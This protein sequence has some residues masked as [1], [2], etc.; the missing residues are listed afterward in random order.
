M[1]AQETKFLHFLAWHNANFIIPV[2]QRNYDWKREQCKQ[3]FD[4]I[5][6]ITK[7]NYRTHFMW[8]IVAYQED[9]YWKELLI[10]DWQQRLTT[11]SLL[12]LALYKVLKNNT[13]RRIRS[14]LIWTGI[15]QSEEIQ[16]NVNQHQYTFHR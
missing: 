5:I 10:I 15:W 13:T 4:D 2:Y 14:I 6:Q 11:L 16:Q 12:L 7:E 1:K 8:A 9:W 3:L